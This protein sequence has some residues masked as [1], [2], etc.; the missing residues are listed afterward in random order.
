MSS[1]F[2]FFLLYFYV[3]Q[4]A[5]RWWLVGTTD[6]LAGSY[7]S[8]TAADVPALSTWDGHGEGRWKGCPAKFSPCGQGE[9]ESKKS[10]LCLNRQPG[11][12]SQ[13]YLFAPTLCTL[14]CPWIWDFRFIIKILAAS[15]ALAEFANT[16]TGL[17]HFLNPGCRM[18]GQ[19]S[20]RH[21]TKCF[22]SCK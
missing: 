10:Q 16:C 4:R 20:I 21:F 8:T 14:L 7:S 2:G 12:Q 17:S 6:H 22:S 11:R 5:V 1:C 13:C 19:R 9:K 18:P 15:S 3:L